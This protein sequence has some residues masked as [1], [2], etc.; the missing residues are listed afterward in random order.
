M[1]EA[2][3][4]RPAGI[5]LNEETQL[6]PE[7]FS[8]EAVDNGVEAAVG[9]SRQVN[10]V[11]CEG[12]VVPQGGSSPL[13]RVSCALQQLDADEDV[14][15]QPADEEHQNHHHNHAQGFLPPRP[16]SA[17][18]LGL[19]EDSANQ[20]VTQTNNG[21]R[22]QKAN[23]DLQP[24]NLK[25]IGKTEVH[26]PSVLGLYNSKGEK[27][28][29]DGGHPDKAAAKLRMLHS[30]QWAAAHGAR[31]GNVSIKAHPCEE[32]DAAVHVD[33]QEK[34]HKGAEDS[35]VVILFIQIENL[36]EGIGHQDE[37]CNSE[38]NKVEI[39]DGHLL[40]VV[41]VYHQN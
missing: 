5:L 30:P 9:E 7:G 14:F 6:V 26:L 8:K 24:L 25:D 34:G 20:R 11:A 29:Q 37:I 39:W 10:N 18:L 38:I 2:V 41:Q 40:S 13:R 1:A 36:N 23:G 12:V 27:G 22:H 17:V 31:Q 33:L 32:E 15:W 16:K 4:H 3:Y 35:V 21:E 19:H 28:G